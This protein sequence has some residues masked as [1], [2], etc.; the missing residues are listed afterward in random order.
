M[1]NMTFGDQVLWGPFRDYLDELNMRLMMRVRAN[2][3][4]HQWGNNLGQVL[5][6]MQDWDMLILAETVRNRNSD[7]FLVN[8][9]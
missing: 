3:G 7:K 9:T 1:E 5:Y 4:E 2:V 6:V 8:T